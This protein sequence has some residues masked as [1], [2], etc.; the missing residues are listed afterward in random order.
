[1]SVQVQGPAGPVGPVLVGVLGAAPAEEA[2]RY[3]FAEAD[4][5]AVGLLVT[6]TGEVP[7]E[8]GVRQADLVQRWS[9]KYPGVPVTT[10]VRRGLDP[11]VILAAASRGC[12]LLV[13]QRPTRAAAAALVDAVSRRAHCPVV[14]V[15]PALVTSA[16]A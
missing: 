13:V 15:D 16:A 10:S 4:D 6:L 12:G 7:A 2:L 1:M 3:A 11:A 14:V 9:E 5:R 8:D